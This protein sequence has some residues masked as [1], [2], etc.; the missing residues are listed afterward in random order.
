MLVLWLHSAEYFYRQPA[1]KAIGD[2]G[3]AFFKY[4]DIGRLGI[5][6]FF[7][8]SGFVICRSLIGKHMKRL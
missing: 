2:G 3:V 6:I 1:M 5:A 8:I 7:I 4:L